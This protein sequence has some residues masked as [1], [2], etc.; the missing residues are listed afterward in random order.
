MEIKSYRSNKEFEI[1]SLEKSLNDIQLALKI[2]EE[3]LN[4]TAQNYE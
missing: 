1:K 2:K 4:R 3:E